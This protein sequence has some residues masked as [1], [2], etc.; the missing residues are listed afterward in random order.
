[1]KKTI[2]QGEAHLWVSNLVAPY[3]TGIQFLLTTSMCGIL[4]T[5]SLKPCRVSY[6]NSSAF[7]YNGKRNP[8]KLVACGGDVIKHREMDW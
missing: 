7:D 2:H 3:G 1:M 6:A 5:P 4:S 8:A